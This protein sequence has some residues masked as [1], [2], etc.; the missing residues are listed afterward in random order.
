MAGAIRRTA[1]RTECG[2]VTEITPAL[3]TLLAETLMHVSLAEDEAMRTD[4]TRQQ[5]LSFGWGAW[6]FGDGT[7]QETPSVECRTR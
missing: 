3:A 1:P 4:P 7:P 5:W 2:R 6:E